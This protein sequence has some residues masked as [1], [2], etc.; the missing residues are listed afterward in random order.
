[1]SCSMSAK[2]CTVMCVVVC[3]YLV[4]CCTVAV[5]KVV[6]LVPCN[7]YVLV[8]LGNSCVKTRPITKSSSP[9]WDQTF[10]L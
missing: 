4:P 10:D 5:D 6:D 3:S 9:A 7:S 8:E 2:Y 1:M